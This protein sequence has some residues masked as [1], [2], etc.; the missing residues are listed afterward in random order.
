MIDTVPVYSAEAMPKLPKSAKKI[1]MVQQY[2][3]EAVQA[4]SKLSRETYKQIKHFNKIE[5]AVFLQRVTMDGFKAG[6][7][8]AKKEFAPAEEPAPEQDQEQ[9]PDDG[10]GAVEND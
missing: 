7:E 1:R 3:D 8:A 5:M 4:A 2:K 10:G 9:S 6:Y